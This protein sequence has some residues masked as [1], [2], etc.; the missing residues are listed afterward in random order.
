MYNN[1]GKTSKL[2]MTA[3]SE[4]KKTFL[5]EVYFTAPLK[6]MTPIYPFPGYMQII[7]LAASAGMMSG[8]N[9]EI[10]INIHSGCHAELT[11]QSY[12][13]IHKMEDG[14]AC[15]KSYITIGKNS[16]FRYNP[17][18]VIPFAHSSFQSQNRIMLED[19]NSQFIMC[20]IISCGRYAY[21]ERFQYQSYQSLT[22]VFCKN[23]L[24]YRDN[25]RY[26]PELFPMDGIGFY[27]QYNVLSNILLIHLNESDL[28]TEKIYA[29]LSSV[30]NIAPGITRLDSH[31]ILVKILACDS[32]ILE[33]INTTVF[34]LCLPHIHP[35][36]S[37]ISFTDSSL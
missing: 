12:E 18:P 5:E 10:E 20:D 8:D 29:Y 37:T 1:F 31:G 21:G 4:G 3:S 23:S 19:E 36:I 13:K 9:Q 2:K 7:L 17:L 25:T 28:L 6:V 24:I 14:Y 26:R 22:E 15:R 27:E 32:Q 30:T 16:F 34:N 11:G 35:K 33:E